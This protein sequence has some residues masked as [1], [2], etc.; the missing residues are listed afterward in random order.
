[1]KKKS[2][3]VISATLASTLLVNNS[4]VVAVASSIT[5]EKNIVEDLQV[6]EEVVE[7]LDSTLGDKEEGEDVSNEDVVEDLNG[8]LSDKDEEKNNG[9]LLD[10]EVDSKV[11]SV[12]GQVSS[13]DEENYP[14]GREAVSIPDKNLLKALN[15]A[16][17]RSNSTASISQE[18]MLKLT[19]LHI[20]TKEIKNVTG[21]EYATNL[22]YLSMRENSISDITPLSKLTKLNKLYLQQNN[23]EDITPLKSLTKLTHLSLGYNNITNISALGSL[24]KLTYLRIYGNNISNITPLSKL[25]A[26]TDLAMYQN[27]VTTLTALSGL[28]S[29]TK[30]TIGENNITDISPLKTLV[31]LTDLRMYDTKVKD[32]SS[33]STLKKIEYFDAERCNIADISVIKN[34]TNLSF[35]LIKDQVI[36]DTSEDFYTT[37]FSTA[38]IVKGKTGERITPS[39]I[40]NSGTHSSGTISWSGLDKKN[41]TLTY[42]FSKNYTVGGETVVFSGK[43]S[44]PIV[45]KDITEPT[46]VV[47]GAPTTWVKSV[48][49][50]VTATDDGSGVSNITLPDGTSVTSSPATY[51]VTSNGKYTFK[52]TDKSGNIAT[53][54][55]NVT[56]IDNTAPSIELTQ[57]DSWEKVKS[58]NVSTMDSESGVDRIELPD[59]T[60]VAGDSAVYRVD[61]NGVYTFKVYDK[62]GNMSTKNITVSKVD[63]TAPSV[64]DWQSDDWDRYSKDISIWATDSESGVDRIELPDGTSVAGDSAVYRVDRNGVYTF[65]VYDNSGNITTKKVTVSKIDKNAPVLNVVCDNETWSS[66]KTISIS[67]TDSESGVN[68]I[69]LPDGSFVMGSSATYK[70]TSNGTYTFKVYDNAWNVSTESVTITKID[71][72][73]PTITATYDDKNWSSSKTIDILATDGR[74]GIR[75]IELPDGTSVMGGSASY[76]VHENGTYIFKAYNYAGNMVSSPVVIS[77]IDKSPPTITAMYDDNNWSSSKEIII[78]ASDSE[79]GIDRIEL[80]NGDTIKGDTTTYIANSN[81]T[82][83]FKAYDKAGREKS[84]SVK[85]SKIDKTPPVITVVHD[86]KVWEK[87][88]V[89]TVSAADLESGVDRIELPNGKIVSSDSASYTVDRN[90]VYEF[91]AYD[92]AGNEKLINVEVNKVDNTIPLL[93]ATYNNSVWEKSKVITISASDLE[94]GISRVELPNGNIVNSDSASYTVDRNGVYEFKAY[95]NA[96]NEKS[97]SVRVDKIDITLPVIT[98]EYDD[99]DWSKTKTINI[100]AI[101]SESGVRSIQLPNGSIVEGSSAEIVVNENG[102]YEFKVYDNVGNMTVEEINITKIDSVSP[103]V[104]AVYDDSTW[105]KS[106]T[107]SISAIDS[108]SGVS[109][110]VM[111]D[112]SIV[113]GSSATITV[114]ESKDY[115]FKVYD[116]VG[117]ITNKV[118]TITKIDDTAPLLDIVYDDMLW[119][120][121]KTIKISA[122]DS[123]SGVKSI[124][125]PDGTVVEASSTEITVTENGP[126]EFKILDN[127]GN[128]RVAVVNISKIDKTAPIIGVNYN[129]SDWSKNISIEVTANDL[130]SGVAKIELP[131]GRFVSAESALYSVTENG[132]YTF[133]AYDSV[134]NVSSKTVVISNI[135]NAAPTLNL[136]YDDITWSRSKSIIANA[137]DT[138]SGLEKIELP[139][140]RMVEN[141]TA[142]YEVDSN[143][144]Y[145]FKAHDRLGNI[146]SVEA[147]IT[148]IDTTAPIVNMTYDDSIWS[149]SKIINISAMDGQSGISR[150]ELPNGSIVNSVSEATYTAVENGMYEFKVYDNVGNVT[151]RR[152]EVT[153]ID[154]SAPSIKTNVDDTQWEYSKVIRISA[155]DSQSGVNK[156][157][158]PDGKVVSDT[159]AEYRVTSNGNY[160]FKVYDNAGNISSKIVSISK[161]DNISPQINTIYD[162]STWEKSKVIR[163]TATDSESGIRSIQLPD[164]KVVNSSTVEYK[165]SANG[166][167]EFKCFDNVGNE[168]SEIVSIT[169]IDTTIPMINLEYDNEAWERLKNIKISVSDSESGIDRIELPD[170]VIVTGKTEA[171]YT[172]EENREYAFKVYDRVGNMNTETIEIS[173]IDKV[174]P[175]V[176]VIYDKDSWERSKVIRVTAVDSESGIKYIELPDGSIINNKDAVEYEVVENGEYVFKIS[177]NTGNI[178]TKKVNITKIDKTPPTVNVS[179]NNK[180]WA[181]QIR[182]DITA[183]DSESGVSKIKLPSGAFVSASEASFTVSTNGSYE[184]KVYD[185]VGNITTEIVE[186]ANIDNTAPTLNVEYDDSQWAKNIDIDLIAVDGESGIDKI[187][188]PDKTEVKGGVA[189]YTVSE[190]GLYEFKAYDKLGNEVKKSVLISC[191][192]NE[193]PQLNL[194]Y[195]KDSFARTVDVSVIAEDSGSGIDKIVMPNGKEVK[196]SVAEFSVIE[197]GSYSFIVY[198]NAGNKTEKTVEISNIDRTPPK[199]K[200]KYNNEL[201]SSSIEVEVEVVDTQSGIDYIELPN[202][203]VVKSNSTTF[204]IK[205]NGE[206]TFK[207]YD[208]LGNESIT[209]ITITNID[210]T[211]PTISTTYNSMDWMNEVEIDIT[212][213][214]EDSGVKEIELPDGTIVEG[215]HAKFIATE[216]GSYTF[217]AV[218]M[219][220]NESQETIEVENI[221]KTAPTLDVVYDKDGW[222]TYIDVHLSGNDTQSGVDR[223]ELPNGREIKGENGEFKVTKNGE[224]VF[225]V[226]DNVGNERVESIS[227]SNIDNTAP[228]MNLIYNNVDWAKSIEVNIDI[229][230]ND[231]GV[232]YIL[233]PDGTKVKGDSATFEVSKNGEYIFKAYDKLGNEKVEK[234][235]I[236]TIDIEPPE[237]NVVYD[238]ESPLTSIDIKISAVDNKSGVDYIL[239]PDGTKVKGDSATFKASENKVYTIKA[240]DKLGN[241]SIENITVSNIDLGG[242]VITLEYSKEWSTSIGIKVSAKD[243]DSEVEKI[244]LPDGTEVKG[245]KAT[246]EVSENGQYVFKAYDDLGNETVRTIIIE[247]IDNTPPSLN[248][249]YDSSDWFKAITLE[250]TASDSQSGIDYIELPSGEKVYSEKATFDISNNG[251]YVFKVYDRLGN[252]TIKKIS[253]SN[254]DKTAPRLEL[255]YNSKDWTKSIVINVLATDEGSGVDRIVLPN[256][257]IVK[258]E[259]AEFTVIDNG[260]YV[261]KVYDRLGNMSEEK[262]D[263]TNIDKLGPDVEVRLDDKDE[264]VSKSKITI[265]ANDTQSGVDYIELPNGKIVKGE[266]AEFTV[267]DN[268]KYVFKV[269]DNIGNETIKTVEVSNIDN[270]GPSLDIKFNDKSWE[271]SVDVNAIATDNKSG[272]EKI[273]LPDGSEVYADEENLNSRGLK[274]LSAKITVSENDSYVF[275]A[276]DKL[277]NETLKTIKVSNIDKIAPEITID[278]DKKW[279]QE[280]NV[281]ISSNDKQSGVESIVLPDGKKHSGDSCEYGIYENGEYIF[282]VY[283]KLG[284]EASK[285]INISNIDRVAPEVK[286]TVV[287]EG[288]KAIIKITATDDLSGVKSIICNNRNILEDLVVYKNGT[289]VIE[290]TDNANNK[291]EIQVTVSGVSNIST[292]DNNGPDNDFGNNSSNKK[293]NSTLPNTGSKSLLSYMSS[294]LVSLLALAQLRSSKHK[295]EDE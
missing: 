48:V 198:D 118:V 98:A 132:E 287:N 8:S 260:K 218:D 46:L 199:I 128:E 66:S 215:D 213:F 244:I 142:E 221:D 23:I 185:S 236:T 171:I 55:V 17:G 203:K 294:L 181:K 26:L 20:N 269:Y 51:K 158:L 289:Y 274:K 104:D 167:Y 84:I 246:F 161:V 117:N 95:D 88:K 27:K 179:F 100:S 252:E 90:G 14:Q 261:F 154:S 266:E 240:Y 45:Y 243:S 220:G 133:K 42:S 277:G 22:T 91:K 124:Q 211:A 205:E 182:I 111:P 209:K 292:G 272:V 204:K 279:S 19:E 166:T 138:D 47:T 257:D 107:I 60:S 122:E 25:T 140:G 32:I 61:R 18:D 189:Q 258:G 183:S 121:S 233:L 141:N 115:I 190:N 71:R 210:I 62:L 264:W 268:G 114:Q 135:D 7:G 36:T 105:S 245:D 38:N 232:D 239:L 137:V 187:I 59:G 53:K 150:I 229:S 230:D 16:L 148:K 134:G 237:I 44:K 109:K 219:T 165:I 180:E 96:G 102:S 101:D 113:K 10:A 196:G 147:S 129:K 291:T 123:Q 156:I 290:V 57:S 278:Y 249:K 192:D 72:A 75:S 175:E 13:G 106:K 160:E 145:V 50:T 56:K 127:I 30:L 5:S 97:I 169:K 52:A 54:T 248:I 163:V 35:L 271:L 197:N 69:E 58:I 120:K 49:L 242:P 64:G 152:V 188:L 63:N 24:T 241:E 223:I 11:D 214:D 40:S 172:V 186:I 93:Q 92:N 78:E 94:S 125:L 184:F 130:E 89:I 143:G 295:K 191:I 9:E 247:N 254:I 149:P 255:D 86:D 131:D 1:M 74:S 259:E 227:I 159:E 21:L 15:S 39:S 6:K 82:Y 178:T 164:G 275:K 200:I 222:F 146:G 77:K 270:E 281:K 276:Y 76:V 283:D 12:L 286:Y 80:P 157:V 85:V 139:N 2:C 73:S 265:S 99:D 216:N 225:K 110:I 173:K 194:H 79:S 201:W 226:Y 31:N 251:E 285:S 168:T 195:N 170:G 206:Y 43:V 284:N 136:I 29:L 28:T 126:Y 267:I 68:K 116:N 176:S 162:D 41:Q 33:L 119:S 174:S 212:A 34:F 231:S 256:G 262:I 288:D 153:K 67:A 81:G 293:D 250:V 228:E 177:D 83:Q 207:S 193:S 103:Q 202:G 155:K 224:Y 235:N 70:V 144:S 3:K 234:I 108:E 253:I 37:T 273:I 282:K 87:S 112:G 208:V 217:K 263:I 65:K 4:G 151:I 238:E 280:V